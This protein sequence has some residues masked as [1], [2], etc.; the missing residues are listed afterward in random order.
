MYSK[1]GFELGHRDHIL[2]VLFS[3][4]LANGLYKLECHITLGQKC[5][6]VTRSSLLGP[7]LSYEKRVLNTVEKGTV[8]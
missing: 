2:Y 4:K 8:S 7:L 6:P 5:L 1:Q 3:S